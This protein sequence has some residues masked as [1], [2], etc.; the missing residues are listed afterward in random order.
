MRS[1]VFIRIMSFE[2]NQNNGYTYTNRERII[3]ISRIDEC[4]RLWKILESEDVDEIKKKSEFIC[5]LF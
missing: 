4:E 1:V 3:H 2:T 5:F